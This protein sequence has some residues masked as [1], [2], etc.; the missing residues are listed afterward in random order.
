VYKYGCRDI[1]MC[2]RTNPL[3]Y[4]WPEGFSTKPLLQSVN[5][6]TCTFVDGSTK[7]VDAIIL[8]TGYKHIF[9]FLEKSLTLVTKNRYWIDGCHKGI[10]WSN[11]P[12][13]MYIGMQSQ[14]Y[15]FNMFDAQAWYARDVIL[16]KIA[17][18]SA[19]E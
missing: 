4:K 1:V 7:D 5:G 11:N 19:A 15:S 3:P 13:M 8:C 2:Y 12:Q 9:P 10:F 14:A 17:L 18:G 16:G 6:K